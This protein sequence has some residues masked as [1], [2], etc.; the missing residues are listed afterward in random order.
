[1]KPILI[2]AAT[3]SFSASAVMAGNLIN[4]NVEAA[5]VVDRE[6]KVGSIT[7]PSD[8]AEKP[9]ETLRKTDRLPGLTQTAIA[10]PEAAIHRMQ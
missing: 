3:I 10:S 2:L 8:T 1:M 7:P 6:L 5:V 4:K 9:A